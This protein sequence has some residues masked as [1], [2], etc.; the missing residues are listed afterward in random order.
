MPPDANGLKL[1]VDRY[2]QDHA[3]SIAY[4]AGC[5][6]FSAAG[7]FIDFGWDI[8]VVNPADIPKPAKQGVIKTDKIDAR[9]IALQLRASNLIKIGIPSLERECLRNL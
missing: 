6:G 5:C 1:Y 7:S 9:N 4:E 2:Y 3:V 8:F